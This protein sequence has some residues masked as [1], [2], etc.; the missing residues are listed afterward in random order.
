LFQLS[1]KC[2]FAFVGG[3]KFPKG[4]PDIFTSAK[5]SGETNGRKTVREYVL[6]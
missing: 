1:F 4:C 3:K 2:V 6:I 5:F